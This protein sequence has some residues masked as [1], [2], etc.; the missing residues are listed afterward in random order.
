[1][2]PDLRCYHHP[3]REATGQCD[4]CGDYLC[5]KCIRGLGE[6]QLCETCRLQ[7]HPRTLGN[8][9][10]LLSIFYFE[11]GALA[12]IC[13]FYA[14]ILAIQIVVNAAPPAAIAAIA[15]I[16][17]VVV[18]GMVALA[19][20]IIREGVFLWRVTRYATCRRLAGWSCLFFPMGTVLGII[21][22]YTLCR[23]EMKAFFE[24]KRP[25]AETLH[26]PK[27]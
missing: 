9:L 27:E 20:V 15:G 8:R 25:P 1:M 14:L 10:Q 24:G 2:Q 23:P 3:E 21:T 16:A 26:S 7:V 22:Y 17:A 13:C 11:A 6:D 18:P 5:A 4:R 12:L 19:Y